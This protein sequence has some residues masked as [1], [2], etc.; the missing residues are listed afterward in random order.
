MVSP[1]GVKQIKAYTSRL[2]TVVE[3]VGDYTVERYSLKLSLDEAATL[4]RARNEGYEGL[5][6]VTKCF[7]E[8][9]EEE[10][11]TPLSGLTNIKSITGKDDKTG[12]QLWIG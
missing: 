1:M 2:T 4:I 3:D 6:L 10:K 9:G 11:G 7:G 8:D 5:Q 12:L